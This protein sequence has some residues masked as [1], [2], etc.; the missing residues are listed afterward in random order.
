MTTELN[1]LTHRTESE[2]N[3]PKGEGAVQTSVTT[4]FS[5]RASLKLNTDMFEDS[6]AVATDECHSVISFKFNDSP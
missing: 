1:F 3:E 2:E 5:F 4:G 6:K